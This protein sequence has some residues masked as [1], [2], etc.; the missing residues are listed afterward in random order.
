M[1]A[2]HANQPLALGYWLIPRFG[3]MG[4]VYATSVG[5][6]VY[7]IGHCLWIP[8]EMLQLPDMRT[9]ATSTGVALGC[10][11]GAW[12]AGLFSLQPGWERLLVGGGAVGVAYVLGVWAL[13]GRLRALVMSLLLWRKRPEA[14]S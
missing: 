14:A 2:A 5:S 12:M 6:L 3:V 13:D 9:V 10:A 1:R 11:G 8:R 4:A 7:A